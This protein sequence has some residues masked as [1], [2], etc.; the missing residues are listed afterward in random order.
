LPQPY[1]PGERA[2]YRLSYQGAPILTDSPLGLDFE[3][4]RALERDF[5]ILGSER[6]SHDL[7]WENAFGAKRLVRDCYN[8]LKVSLRERQAPRRRVDLIFR[9]YNEGAAFR[10]FLP[11]QEG[12]ER[13]TLM[14]ENTGF[15]FAR[16]A[17]AFALNKGSFNTDNEGEYWRISLD[18]I[19]PA[20][21][22]NLPLLVEMP[23]GPWMAL[24]EADL[25]NY[26]ECMWVVSPV[27]KTRWSANSRRGRSAWMRSS[28]ALHPRELPGVFCWSTSGRVGWSRATT[29]S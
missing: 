1:A 27:L 9:A 7:T 28:R 5:E 20:S 18:Q 23:G 17:S 14:A 6:R 15:Y 8:Q 21:I 11:K 12:L 2:Y 19:K 22:I 10:Y 16:P 4:A 25:T 24:L 26:A 29:S 13:F 3:G